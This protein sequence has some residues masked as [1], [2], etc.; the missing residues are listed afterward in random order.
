MPHIKIITIKIL[1]IIIGGVVNAQTMDKDVLFCY[2]AFDVNVPRGYKYI[3]LEGAH[4]SKM[5][6][7]ILKMNNQ[8]VLAY[9]SL[10]EV[11]EAAY[12]FDDIKD[13]TLGKNKNWNSYFLDLENSETIESLIQVFKTNINEKGLDGMFLDNIDNYTVFG[14]LHHKKGELINFLK[15]VKKMFPDAFFMQNAGLTLLDYTADY[16]HSIAVESVVSNYDFISKI[17]QLREEQDFLQRLN[18]VKQ[19]LEKHPLPLVV[20]EYAD[21]V[22]LK[23]KI[24]NRLE[25]TGWMYFIGNIDLQKI[26]EITN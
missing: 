21:A 19:T 1:L 2:G 4:F 12:F 10:G 9:V 17:Y 24:K 16:V 26:P 25:P 20:I 11:N 22:K 15:A 13:F 8:K 23:E 5:D 3:V 14:T 18:S 6:I 7:E